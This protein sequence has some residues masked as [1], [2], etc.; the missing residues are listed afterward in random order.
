M[1]LLAIDTA[2]SRTAVALRDVDTGANACLLGELDLSAAD[3]PPP[4]GRP[5]HAQRLLSLIDELMRQATTDWE[6][7]DRIAVGVGPGTFTGLRIGIASAQA[8][9]TARTLP[10][11]GVSTLRSLA[12]SAHERASGAATLA[13]IDARR[14][15]AFVAGWSSDADPLSAAPALAPCVLGPEQ[16]ARLAGASGTA[17]R[18][19]GDG[20]VKFRALLE[21]AGVEVPPDPS[22]LHRVSAR[23]HCRLG[24]LAA[25]AP[26]GRVE[27]DYLRVPDAEVARR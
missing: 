2:T 22:P 8:L 23:A 14:G 10:L 26:D 13:V 9:A 18:A 7:I 27:P 25:P 12:L 3:D 24:A 17:S 21:G 6:S 15:E 11:V 5:G 1:R 20:A 4:G 19:V 16:L